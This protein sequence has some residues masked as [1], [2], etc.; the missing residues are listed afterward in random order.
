M[1]KASG[2]GGGKGMRIAWNDEE[3]I[4]GY[5]LS[6]AEAMSSFNNGTMFI[7]KYIDF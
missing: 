1:V 7:E 2:G 4:S 6:Q 3:A 5:R